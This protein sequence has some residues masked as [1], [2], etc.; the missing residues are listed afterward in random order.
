MSAVRICAEGWEKGKKGVREAKQVERDEG[1][2]EGW[3]KEGLKRRAGESE[4]G[5]Q[6]RVGRGR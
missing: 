4:D 2:E 3:S 1:R 6:E 5:T